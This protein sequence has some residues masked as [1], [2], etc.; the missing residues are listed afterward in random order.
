MTSLR[1]APGR[2][3]AS[4][5]AERPACVMRAVVDTNV[6][7][8]AN[9]AHRDVGEEC[10]AACTARL[11]EP[12]KRGRVVIDDA[13]EIV[14]EYLHKTEPRRGRRAGDA[15]FEVAAEQSGKS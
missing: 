2:K 7:L 6:I 14:E 12:A 8:V 15:F 10:H 13:N 4:T 3:P 9:G 5:P 1:A 11:F